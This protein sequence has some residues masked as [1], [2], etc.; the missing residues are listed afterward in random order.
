MENDTAKEDRLAQ[1]EFASEKRATK[2]LKSFRKRNLFLAA[3]REENL[4]ELYTFVLGE[5]LEE[6]VDL[7]ED[8]ADAV[9]KFVQDVIKRKNP[10][11]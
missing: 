7:L 4:E 1:I 3:A 8:D 2:V 5:E 10:K 11:G 9:D 6:L